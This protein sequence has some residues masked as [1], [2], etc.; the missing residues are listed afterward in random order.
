MRDWIPV[1]PTWERNPD[2][3]DIWRR[4][5]VMP[6]LAL[7]RAEQEFLGTVAGKRLAVLTAADGTA[8]IALAAM[9]AQVTVIDPTHGALDVLVVHAQLVGLELQYLR[10]DLTDL[11]SIQTGTF[12]IAY[13]AQASGLVAD[14]TRYYQCVN[15]IL[16]S[17]GRLI[18][19]EYH[20]VR[21]IWKN[22]PGSPRLARSYFERRLPRTDEELP[23]AVSS[24]E[25]TFDRYKYNW[26]LSDHF[27]SL[28][29]AGF[30]VVGIEEVGDVRQRWEVPNLTGLPEQLVMAADKPA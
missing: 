21:R 8:P 4:V 15:R 16:V 17:G 28:T 1:A 22:E 29:Q 30:H 24:P 7:N 11:C 20:P 12:D 6:S 25:L 27:R 14:L 2:D 13:A 9:G 23:D 19:N 3:K 26:T 10:A 5:A 18:V